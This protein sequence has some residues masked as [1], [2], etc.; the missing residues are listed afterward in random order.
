M[1]MSRTGVHVLRG[2]ACGWVVQRIEEGKVWLW[3]S[4]ARSGGGPSSG[5]FVVNQAFHGFLVALC[6]EWD[7][8]TRSWVA[9]WPF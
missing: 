6:N 1:R 5:R 2:V 8:Y 9:F 3:K 7:V 4:L